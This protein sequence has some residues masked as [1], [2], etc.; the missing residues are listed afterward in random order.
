VPLPTPYM[1]TLP[2]LLC[3]G[4][5]LMQLVAFNTQHVRQGVC[6]RGAAKWQGEPCPGPIGPDILAKTG[7]L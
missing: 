1:N 5:G 7:H 3:S 6:Q 2:P 4:E